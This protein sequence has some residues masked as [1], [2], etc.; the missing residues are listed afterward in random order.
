MNNIV[1]SHGNK[2]LDPK[3]DFYAFSQPGQFQPSCGRNFNNDNT[4]FT[5]DCTAPP[6]TDSI[7][8]ATYSVNGIDMGSG[9]QT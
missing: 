4:V 3:S 1:T 5:I 6:G 2:V 8:G 9:I 7:A